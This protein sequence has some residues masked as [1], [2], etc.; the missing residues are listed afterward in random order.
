MQLRT[1]EKTIGELKFTTTK[2]PAMRAFGLLA[3]LMKTV[4]PALGAL[5]KM[6]PNAEIDPT[7][8]GLAEAFGALDAKEA[9]ALIPAI[10]ET[11]TV[12]IPDATGSGR[13]LSLSKTDNINT[14]FTVVGLTTMFQALG[15][16][17]QVNYRDFSKGSAPAAP[18]SPAANAS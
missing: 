3:R 10:F 9:E 2:L 18:Q 12:W 8:A 5:M 13:E 11:T 17:L 7:S 1:E 15:F 6:D 14:A 4:G 16:V